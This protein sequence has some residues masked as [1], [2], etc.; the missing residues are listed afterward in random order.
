MQWP[1]DK[2]MPLSLLQQ[3]DSPSEAHGLASNSGEPSGL[4]HEGGRPMGLP[5]GI[6]RTEC[7]T[8]SKFVR[9]AL[10]NK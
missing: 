6:S 4:K 5:L 10:K 8:G 3:C 7:I 2:H 1:L 9:L